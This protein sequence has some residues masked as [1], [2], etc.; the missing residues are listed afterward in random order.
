[1]AWSLAPWDEA[2]CGF[3]VLQITALEIIGTNASAEMQAFESER[4]RIGAGLVSCRLSHECMQESILLQDHGFRFI[5]MLYRPEL[6]LSKLPVD[7]G[8]DDLS[9]SRASDDDMPVLLGIARTSFRNERFRFDPRLDPDVSDRR[10]QNWVAD[11]LRH[12]TQDLYVVR[13]GANRVG[14]FVTELLNDGTCYWHL[15]AVAPG[16]QGRGF[17]RRVWSS[18]LKQA[19]LSGAQRVR[20][21]IAARNFKV[22]NLYARLGFFFPPPAMTFHWVRS[23]RC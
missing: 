19:S 8:D 20:T 17:G 5:E 7:G 18:M 3:P 10:Y 14:F 21:S 2:V 4:E 12:A 6:D 1:M 22:L 15:N 11:S 23:P 16:M 13:E 9:V